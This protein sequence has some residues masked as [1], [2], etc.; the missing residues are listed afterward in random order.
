MKKLG[1]FVVCMMLVLLCMGSV[2]ANGSKE[3]SASSSA[4]VQA[5]SDDPAT[6][7]ELAKQEGKV[8]VYSVSSRIATAASSFMEQY[9]GITVEAYDMRMPSILEKLERETEAGIRNA[10][11]VLGNDN[12]GTLTYESIPAG[13]V[14]TWIPSDMD[15]LI[16]EFKDSPLYDFSVELV[17]VFYNNEVYP[18]SPIKSWW[19][20]TL[21][22]WKGKVMMPDPMSAPELLS[23]FGAFS[24]NSDAMAKDYEERFG[25]KLVLNGTPDAG[26]EFMKRLLANDVVIVDSQGGAITAIG[27]PGQKN[28]S[29]CIVVSSKLRER[30]KNLHIAIATELTPVVGVTN[31]NSLIM[32]TNCPHPNAA[33]LFIR[34]VAGEAD[35]Q[36]R[37]FDGF[38]VI[39]AWPT[40]ASGVTISDQ[41]LS[42][43]AYWIDDH[44]YMYRN[45]LKLRDAWLT[46]QR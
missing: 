1:R 41:P 45:G 2:F 40:R 27:T 36:G 23:L 30:E 31:P 35:G 13:L 10:D 33:K 20:L 37:G 25:E 6:L 14:T 29:V 4:A 15:D 9:P 7:Y 18:E 19:D 22:E 24:K 32:V 12:G 34:W 43:L 3:S 16:G 44:D 8:V 21:P 28:P 38:K 39:G 26:Y 17:T 42:D 11:V 46:Y 5:V